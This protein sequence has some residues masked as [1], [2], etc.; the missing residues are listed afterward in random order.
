MADITE[1]VPPDRDT[2]EDTAQAIHT[3]HASVRD[4]DEQVKLLANSCYVQQFSVMQYLPKSQTLSSAMCSP[5]VGRHAQQPPWSRWL[6]CPTQRLLC[7]CCSTQLWAEG[8]RS[9]R[10]SAAV[11][12][13]PS[14]GCWTGCVAA[15][16]YAPW[17]TSWAAWSLEAC[18]LRASSCSGTRPSHIQAVTSQP[19]PTCCILLADTDMPLV[20]STGPCG[21]TCCRFS[22]LAAVQ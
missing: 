20:R 21:L 4:P 14:Q 6:C 22:G 8:G 19:L 17:T 3:L 16:W 7:P 2:H 9:L 15:R 1:E 5:A 10:W 12:S 18:G 11:P 13:H